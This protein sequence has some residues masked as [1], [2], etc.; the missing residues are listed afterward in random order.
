MII[1]LIWV[2]ADTPWSMSVASHDTGLWVP[3]VETTWIPYVAT[4]PFGAFDGYVKDREGPPRA[5]D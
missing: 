4:M 5:E 3:Y 2:S 1:A